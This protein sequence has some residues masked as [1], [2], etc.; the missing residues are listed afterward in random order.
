MMLRH[1][2]ERGLHFGVRGGRRLLSA[3]RMSPEALDREIQEMNDEMAELFGSPI[4][5]A[6]ISD[7]LPPQPQQPP[8]R[9]APRSIPPPAPSIPPT[10]SAAETSTARSALLAK[11]LQTTAELKSTACTDRSTKLAKCIAEC[12]RAVAALDALQPSSAT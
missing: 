4:G 9:A 7:G 5:E 10:T 1:V 6:S 12:A 2:P 3:T 11:I 8:L